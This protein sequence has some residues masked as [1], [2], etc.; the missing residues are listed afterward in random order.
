MIFRTCRTHRVTAGLPACAVFHPQNSATA[1]LED[2]TKLRG[3]RDTWRTEKKNTM[4]CA[5]F[6]GYFG[7]AGLR[8][9]VCYFKACSPH[10][11]L[12]K[13][14]PATGGSALK[15]LRA[16]EEPGFR[17][18]GPWLISA[19]PIGGGGGRALGSGDRSS[20]RLTVFR[21]G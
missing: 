19:G 20:E 12:H 7:S 1:G 10:G 21:G 13:V 14:C 11:T 9:N 3:H 15:K 6:L 2:S 17:S 8:G 18:A 16:N 4:T 5:L